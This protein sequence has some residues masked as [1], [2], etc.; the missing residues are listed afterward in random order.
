MQKLRLTSGSDLYEIRV[1]DLGMFE[2][3]A[4]QNPDDWEEPI[5]RELLQTVKGEPW[6][7]PGQDRRL[8]PLDVPMP[9]YLRLVEA[10][11]E[12]MGHPKEVADAALKGASY[13]DYGGTITILGDVFEVAT[14]TV[15]KH[16][17]R[18]QLCGKRNVEAQ[19]LL[20][21]DHIRSFNGAPVETPH[22]KWP[23]DLPT[24]RLLMDFLQLLM[25][26][27]LGNAPPVVL[28]DG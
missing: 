2:H 16:R 5:I 4:R 15:R 6:P 20:L 12:H 11:S 10:V 25:A 8:A 22:M 28:V 7:G 9:V 27:G 21:R 23:F 19:L 13:S 26:G 24:T 17:E 14:P 3:L 1:P 18:M